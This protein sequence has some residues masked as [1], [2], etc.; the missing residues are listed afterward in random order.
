M[1]N[2]LSFSLKSQP[3]LLTST[4]PL[5][6]F[7]QAVSTIP[8]SVSQ[9]VSE[10]KV[11]TWFMFINHQKLFNDDLIRVIHSTLPSPKIVIMLIY[12]YKTQRETNPAKTQNAKQ[13]SN[14]NDRTCQ[15]VLLR[16]FN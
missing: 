9:S 15:Y 12:P 5:K 7:S 13:G 4:S 1:C 10:Q 8:K 6:P 16:F 11:L 14:N 3:P 2:S